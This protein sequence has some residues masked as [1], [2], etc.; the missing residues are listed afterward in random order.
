VEL[1]AARRMPRQALHAETLGFRH[2][3]TGEAVV[4]RSPLPADMAAL[5]AQVFGEAGAAAVAR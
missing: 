5:V 1:A 2:P 3:G 4:F